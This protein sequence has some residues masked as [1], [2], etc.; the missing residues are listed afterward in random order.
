MTIEVTDAATAALMTGNSAALDAMA[1]TGEASNVQASSDTSTE[2]VDE[3]MNEDYQVP[4]LDS[5]LAEGEES[6]QDTEVSEDE[7]EVK[8]SEEES[9]ESSE[10]EAKTDDVEWIKADGK[11]IKVDYSDKERIKKAHEMAAGMRKAFAERDQASNE[12]KAVSA[13]LSELKAIWNKLE[14]VKD[15]P[16][17]LFKLV[18]GNSLDS[19]VQQKQAE[20]QA[21]AD[22]SPEERV[23]MESQKRIEALET[24][25]RANESEIEEKLAKVNSDKE[26]AELANLQSQINPAFNKYR[27][28][29][30]LGDADAEHALDES[31]WMAT[32][33]DLESVPDSDLTPEMIERAF[34]LRAQS[35]SKVI[36]KQTTKRVKKTISAT[37]KRATEAAQIAAT[38]GKSSKSGSSN[39]ELA[40]RIRGGDLMGVLSNMN[41]YFK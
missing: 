4:D 34:K 41:K 38:T 21:F 40:Q 37:K 28:A 36:N 12:A 19:Y 5:Y 11:K 25:L 14:S 16:E 20:A 27:F 18:T 1:E 2:V 24:K 30:K 3:V 23:A 31:L 22:A 32:L 39:K 13:E 35:V 9:E 10:E 7:E 17:D 33:S 15:R 6:E 26:A 8:V 29:G